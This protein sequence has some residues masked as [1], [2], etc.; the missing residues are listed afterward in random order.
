MGKGK[1]NFTIKLNIRP[2]WEIGR[3]HA[4]H[5]SG[6]GQ[7]D[8]RPKRERTRSAQKRKAVNDGW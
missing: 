2:I 7:H 8:N 6:S 5:R 4:E 1:K 3:G